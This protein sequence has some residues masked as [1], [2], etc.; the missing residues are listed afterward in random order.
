MQKWPVQHAKVRF[1]DL[2]KTCLTEG[3]QMI[4]KRGVEVAVLVPVNEWRRLTRTT[5][6]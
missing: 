5:Q 3:P 6:P 2:L 4:S 1:S